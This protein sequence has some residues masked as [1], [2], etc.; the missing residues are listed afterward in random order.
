[1]AEA[2]GYTPMDASQLAAAYNHYDEVSRFYWMNS[3]FKLWLDY[4]LVEID[5]DLDDCLMVWD[6]METDLSNC[7]YGAADDFDAVHAVSVVPCGFFGGGGLRGIAPRPQKDE[8]HD[9]GNRQG[10]DEPGDAKMA[11]QRRSDCY[12]GH[13]EPDCS[14]EHLI[15][16]FIRRILFRHI[17]L[18]STV[19]ACGVYGISQ[20]LVS[21]QGFSVMISFYHHSRFFRIHWPR[22]PPRRHSTL[23]GRV[24]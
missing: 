3:G 21:S 5:R 13:E 14:D 2:A 10:D 1:M 17:V 19:V 23:I 6:F 20:Y 8:R 16:K 15:G 18:L 4:T 9:C 7:G 12:Q 11:G 24:V 22:Q